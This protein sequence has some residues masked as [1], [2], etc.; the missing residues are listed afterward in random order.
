MSDAEAQVAIEAFLAAI[1]AGDAAAIDA[2]VLPGATFD[3][4]FQGAQVPLDRESWLAIV[5]GRASGGLRNALLM[6]LRPDGAG[7]KVDTRYPDVTLTDR[8]LLR[9]GPEGW[10]VAGVLTTG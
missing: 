7:F 6:T 10:R 8:V 2:M 3:C 9:P 4:E 1:D 5:R